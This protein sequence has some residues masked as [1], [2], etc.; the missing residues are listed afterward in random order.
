[1]Y[2]QNYPK[3]AESFNA[4]GLVYQYISREYRTALYCH[5]QALVILTSDQNRDST[6]LKT[7]IIL[8]NLANTYSS[9]GD[10]RNVTVALTD[11][12]R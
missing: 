11:I 12:T 5:S 4:L 9:L 1:M 6:A 10:T 7:G 8:N 3:I 2:G